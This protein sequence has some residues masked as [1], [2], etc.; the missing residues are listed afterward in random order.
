MDIRQYFP[1][2]KELFANNGVIL[3]YLFG[4]QVEGRAGPLSDIDIAVLL[5][6]DVP[7]ERWT[8]VQIELIC[9]LMSIFHR[10]DIDV[11]ILNRATPLLAWEVVKYG[12][13]IYEDETRPG[14]DF[15]VYA[16]SRYA[17]TEP[18]RRLAQRYLEE[19]IEERRKARMEKSSVPHQW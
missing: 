12:K 16:A 13:V 7:S 4:S 2:L 10:D 8:D 1:Q 5:G 18:L 19:W 11:V 17:D 14:V 15:A 6:P 3:A 9:E